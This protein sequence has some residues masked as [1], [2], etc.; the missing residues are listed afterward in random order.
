MNDRLVRALTADGRVRV[1]GVN[2]TQSLNNAY[3][4]HHLSPLAI[5]ALGRAMSASLLLA[6]NMKKERARVNVRVAGDGGLGLIYADAGFDGT[7]RGFVANPQ[8][9]L[10]PLADG[11]QNVSQG[12]GHTGFFKVMRDVGYGEPYSS[13]VELIAGDIANDVAWYLASSE[14]T[15]S[16]LILTEVINPE[17]SDAPVQVAAG[18]LLQ[19]M[20]V[21]TLRIAKTT[22][23][24]QEELLVQLEAKSNTQN[25]IHLLLQDQTI[26]DVMTELFADMHLD[27]LPMSKD[28]RFHCPC[29][30]DRMLAAMKM[31]GEEDLRSMIAEDLGAEATCHFC[32]EV[33]HATTEQLNTLLADLLVET[34]A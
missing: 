21:A 8:F 24:S 27:I 22:N 4:R 33:Y 29:T 23:R 14:Q 31:F 9:T 13:T 5:A 6:S 25:F 18:L 12:V 1:I 10:P 16:K 26:E 20:P 11:Q 7:I 32:G 30:L 19:I 17:N 28:V 2:I 15:F 3:R 34:K